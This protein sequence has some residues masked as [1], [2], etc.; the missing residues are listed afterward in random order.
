MQ[1]DNDV[2]KKRHIEKKKLHQ[3]SEAFADRTGLEPA[4]SAVTGR[5]SNQLNYRS[6]VEIG[7]ANLQLFYCFQRIRKIK[8][9]ITLN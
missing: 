2:D 7:G 6:K 4:T 3:I 8:T 1:T 5:H 9:Q